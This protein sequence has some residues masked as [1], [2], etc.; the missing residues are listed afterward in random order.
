[1]WSKMVGNYLPEK[2]YIGH[3]NQKRKQALPEGNLSAIRFTELKPE[4]GVL[5][6]AFIL[7]VFSNG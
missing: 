7:A 5:L 3:V 2:H 1:M 4:P 6:P